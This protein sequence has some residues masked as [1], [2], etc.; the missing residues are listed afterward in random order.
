MI[1]FRKQYQNEPVDFH[2]WSQDKIAEFWWKK[3]LEWVLKN[4]L[5][6]YDLEDKKVVAT[7]SDIIYKELE[8]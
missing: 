1:E 4:R 7:D 5:P 3:A 2:L 8:E 6:Y